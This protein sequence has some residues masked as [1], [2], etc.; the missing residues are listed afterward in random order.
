MRS[1]YLATLDPVAREQY[2]DFIRLRRFR[3]SLLVRGDAPSDPRTSAER[4]RAMHVSATWELANV[5]ANGGVH[6]SARSLDPA[7]GGGGPVRKLLDELVAK[8]PATLPVA[9]LDGRFDLRSL[10]RPLETVLLQAYEAG[11]VDLHLQPPRSRSCR[12]SGPSPARWRDCR[13]SR[14]TR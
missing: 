8:Q 13:R 10:S 5:A 3:Q 14:A 7:S 9:S 6:K 11:L 1:R 4:V 12:P 2:L